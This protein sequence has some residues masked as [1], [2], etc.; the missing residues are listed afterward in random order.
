MLQTG[1]GVDVF[2]IIAEVNT[3]AEPI[4]VYVMLG[5]SAAAWCWYG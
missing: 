3:S 5:L 2:L 1:I 4:A